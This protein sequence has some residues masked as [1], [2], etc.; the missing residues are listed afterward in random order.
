VDDPYEAPAKAE[1]VVRTCEQSPEQSAAQIL[2]YLEAQHLL[3]Q[4]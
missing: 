4:A 1:I 2:S 3:P